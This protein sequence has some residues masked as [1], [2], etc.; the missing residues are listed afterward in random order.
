MLMLAPFANACLYL[1]QADKERFAKPDRPAAAERENPHATRALMA[2][3]KVKQ[4][5]KTWSTSAG[6]GGLVDRAPPSRH[7]RGLLGGGRAVAVLRFEQP[8]HLVIR[9]CLREQ[10]ALA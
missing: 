8:H 4:L 3:Q 2:M 10:E 5:P 6:T 9:P 1:S 7:Q